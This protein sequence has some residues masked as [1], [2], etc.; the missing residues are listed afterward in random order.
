MRNVG[1]RYV[2]LGNVNRL[3]GVLLTID[4]P[5]GL[6]EAAAEKTAFFSLWIIPANA[7]TMT[8]ARKNA[9]KN[10]V[11]LNCAHLH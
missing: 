3:Y 1:Q 6:L 9:A 11:S 10:L 7:K 4:D 2:R 5:D 8:K